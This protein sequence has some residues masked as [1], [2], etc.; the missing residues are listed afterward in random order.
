M[1]RQRRDMRRTRSLA[2]RPRPAGLRADR[3]SAAAGRLVHVE[4]EGLRARCAP[5]GSRGTLRRRCRRCGGSVARRTF[6]RRGQL[7]VAF[8]EACAPR[9]LLFIRPGATVCARVPGRRGMSSRGR[10]ARAVVWLKGS[11]KGSRF[12]RVAL[13]VVDKRTVV[14][15]AQPHRSTAAAAPKQRNDVGPGEHETIFFSEKTK[16]QMLLSAPS[17]LG[18]TLCNESL[19][20]G[21]RISDGI[22]I[23]NGAFDGAETAEHVASPTRAYYHD[24]W[25]SPPLFRHAHFSS[26]PVPS[27]QGLPSVWSGGHAVARRRVCSNV[28]CVRVARVRRLLRRGCGQPAGYWVAA[29]RGWRATACRL[30]YRFPCCCRADNCGERSYHSCHEPADYGAYGTRHGT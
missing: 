27:E 29:W 3:V 18:Y 12:L 14:K 1:A 16:K 26:A 15:F 6:L 7:G 25:C 11:S 8:V 17:L 30:W 10:R 24:C 20:C 19:T 21:D 2:A 9:A 23:L 4:G 22:S 5:V 28:A 13:D